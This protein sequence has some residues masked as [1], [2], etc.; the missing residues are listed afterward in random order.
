MPLPVVKFMANES[1]DYLVRLNQMI[2]EYN[3]KPSLTKL[4]QVDAFASQMLD[5]YKKNPDIPNFSGMKWI[6]QEPVAKEIHHFSGINPEQSKLKNF[7]SASNHSRGLNKDLLNLSVWKKH[8]SPKVGNRSSQYK[9]LDNIIIKVGVAREIRSKGA[10]PQK[11][12]IYFLALKNLQTAVLNKLN[13]IPDD[14]PKMRATFEEVLNQTNR[15]LDAIPETDLTRGFIQAPPEP[16]VIGSILATEEETFDNLVIHLYESQE[17]FERDGFQIHY[18]GGN[19]NKNWLA[20]NPETGERYVLRLEKAEELTTNYVLLEQAKTHPRLKS[21]IAQDSFYYPTN[22]VV[23]QNTDLPFNLAVSE[24]CSRGDI[25]NFRQQLNNLPENENNLSRITDTVLD[26]TEQVANLALDF[27]QARLPYMDIKAENFLI[28]DDGT[29]ITA[30]LKSIAPIENPN[31]VKVNNV[32]TT[33]SLAPPEMLQ[34]GG[35]STINTE[36]F[37]TFQVGLMMYDLMLGQLGKL[38]IDNYWDTK[39]L[40]FSAPVFATEKGR[41]VEALIRAATDPDPNQRPS[42]SQLIDTCNH[43]RSDRDLVA[44]Q[45]AELEAAQN[46]R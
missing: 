42:L 16:P 3:Q 39:T 14:K 22:T 1:N 8:T 2:T 35:G 18:L 37:A 21:H 34:V 17:G 26:L 36:N 20:A 30:D 41:T 27:N 45:Q 23:I 38:W 44:A 40:D 6:L 11:N 12:E 10:D 15:A 9:D 33:G 32:T 4:Q 24:F 28:R 29:V 31:Q 19:N 5:F 43:L 46:P 13:E 25:L 7:I